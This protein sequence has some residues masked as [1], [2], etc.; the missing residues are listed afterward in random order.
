MILSLLPVVL[1]AQSRSV[2]LE[3]CLQSAAEKNAYVRNAGLDVL[4]MGEMRTEARWSY[5]PS[6]NASAIGYRALDPML[7]ITLG[8]ILGGSDYAHQLNYDLSSAAYEHGIK[9]YYESLLYGYTVGIT[10]IQPLYMGGRI[11]NANR[12]ASLGVESA[13]IK[14]SVIVREIRDSVE[15]KYWRVVALQEKLKTLDSTG[16]FLDSLV[17]TANGAAQAGL[18]L[19]SDLLQ[20]RLKCSELESGRLKLRGA[21]KLAK[22]DLF[23]TAGIGY[24]YLE[25]GDIVL[26]DLPSGLPAPE[27]IIRAEE[28]AAEFDESRL[29]TMQVEAEQLRKRMA[30]GEYLPQLALGAG[31]GMG[32]LMGRGE[33]KGNAMAFVTLTIPLTDLGKAAARSRRFDYEIQKAR[34]EKTFLDAQLRLQM[35]MYRLAVETSWEDIMVAEKAVGV[36]EEA[37]ERAIADFDAGMTGC[38]DVMQCRLSLQQAMEKLTD[39]R[40]AYRKAA[41]AYLHRCGKTL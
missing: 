8:D 9:P 5:L 20:L 24:T 22:A 33:M 14:E 17:K 6:V 28:S 13:G 15:N 2:T 35:A 1:T 19:D 37:V 26:S 29:L 40:M 38:T 30:V 4:S 41:S 39:S 34:N 23:N 21:V 25:L 16:D 18:I 12:L 36:A 7:K 31:Y 11:R 10:A 32:D 3:D 27:E